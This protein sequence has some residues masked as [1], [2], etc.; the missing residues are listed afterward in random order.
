MAQLVP[1]PRADASSATTAYRAGEGAAREP[2]A[3]QLATDGPI[4]AGDWCATLSGFKLAGRLAAAD[5]TCWRTLPGAF[6]FQLP[7]DAA[8]SRH[9]FVRPGRVSPA[10]WPGCFVSTL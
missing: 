3:V 4:A 1:R 6:G 2:G 10:L 9:C 7:R 5:G 8:V